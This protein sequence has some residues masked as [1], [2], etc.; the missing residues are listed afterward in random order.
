[1]LG[2]K[3]SFAQTNNESEAYISE[4]YQL[5]SES[6][7]L[8]DQNPDSSLICFKLAKARF[9]QLNFEEDVADC[10]MNIA[11]VY[12]EKFNNSDS[13]IYYASQAANGYENLGLALKQA[14][15]LKY[16]GMLYGQ[17][18]N[19]FDAKKI[20]LDAVEL[21]E[22]QNYTEG[23]AVCYF[24]IASSYE[25]IK[26]SDSCLHYI[27]KANQIWRERNQF[28]R[29]IQNNTFLIEKFTADS[30]FQLILNK[31]FH[32]NETTIVEPGISDFTKQ[33]FYKVAIQ[34]LSSAYCLAD[35]RK[36]DKYERLL[37]Q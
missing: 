12:Y 33:Q 16:I 30:S 18:G 17:Q 22:L 1:M 4:T 20:I 7:S 5:K 11:F 35:K 25:V 6:E 23:T 19:I 26:Q 8:Y 9:Q 28:E 3:T 32:E 24:N 37:N 10:E 31:A 21:F 15:V 34:Y 14:N 29:I 13:A 36:L 2:N 27:N